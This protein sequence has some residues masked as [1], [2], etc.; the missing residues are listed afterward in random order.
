[1]IDEQR[2]VVL[3][4]VVLLLMGRQKGSWMWMV[5]PQ[6]NWVTSAKSQSS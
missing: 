1:M 6:E 2:Q 4:S 5:R 3:V